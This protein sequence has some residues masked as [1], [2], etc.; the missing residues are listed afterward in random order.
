MKRL[1]RLTVAA[2]CVALVLVLGGL[3]LGQGDSLVSL[4]YLEETFVPNLLSQGTEAADKQLTQTY[5]EALDKLGA[6]AGQAGGVSGF[7]EGTCARG[8][9]ARLTAGSG[10]FL[11]T[12][13][14]AV[15]HDGAFIDVT[16][17]TV[18][19]SGANLTAG[20]RYLAGEDTTATVAIRSGLARCGAEGV[21]TWTRSGEP[22]APFT[23]VSSGDWYAAAVDYAYFGGLFTGM[24]DDTFAPGAN[25]DRAMMMTVLYHLAGSPESERLS[26]SSAFQDVPTDRWYVTFVSWA[27]QQGVSAG[28]GDNKFSPTQP[29]TREQV[30][31]LLHNFAIN[32]M[33]LSLEERRDLSV[34]A[35]ADQVSFWASD[36]MSWAV[37]CGV[38]GTPDGGG[39]EPGRGATR[40]E[41]ASML[42]NFSQ[43]YL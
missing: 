28:T 6:L 9:M 7:A 2:L 15:S 10:F 42:M 39:L 21:Y 38:I 23:D 4:K 33:K 26:A 40:A 3:A 20:H 18:V 35:D 25:M 41:V 31:V 14:A 19:A 5:R 22:A 24:G 34:Y 43:N 37:A 36:A 8:D 13:E 1:W 11:R 17:G 32:Y 16:E 29:V 12:G 30:V 27:A